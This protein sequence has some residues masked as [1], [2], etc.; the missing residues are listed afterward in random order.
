MFSQSF[1]TGVDRLP[2]QRH[3]K[4]DQYIH[5]NV[6][7]PVTGFEVLLAVVMIVAIF[8]DIAPCCM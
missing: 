2:V 1:L 6:V 3:V 5:I 7:C 4:T 8:W